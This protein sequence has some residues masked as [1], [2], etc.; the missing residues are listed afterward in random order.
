MH[1]VLLKIGSVTIYS[2]GV[3]V[4]VGFALATVLIYRRAPKFNLNREKCVDLAIT[5]LIS[6][7]VGARLL[8]VL[9]NLRFYAA[10]PLEIIMLSKGGLVW[11]G[12]F[13]AG[14]VAML[15]YVRINALS[16]W[17]V[18]DLVAPYV[19]LAQGF[20]RIG[21]FLNGCCYGVTVAP[22]FPLGVVFPPESDPRLPTQLISAALLF[23]IFAILVI[24][25]NRRRFIG[26]IFLAY[27]MLYSAKRFVI[28]FFR[29]DNPRLFLSLTMSQIISAV[30]FIAAVAVFALKARRWKNATTISK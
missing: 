7:I 22:G 11:Y 8:F 27:C 3:M 9:L 19:A 18:V 12:G 5:I 28:E 29:G 14:L 10:N 13:I 6:G 24:W 2:Y 15:I 30:I 20:G 4:A 25:Q 26:E 16:F 23:L 1:P 21:C 17:S